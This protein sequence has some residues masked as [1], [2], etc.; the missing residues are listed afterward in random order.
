[1]LDRIFVRGGVLSALGIT[2][3]LLMA[4]TRNNA[5]PHGAV[6]ALAG[7]NAA[8][9]GTATLKVRNDALTRRVVYVAMDGKRQRLGV[10]RAGATTDLAVPQRY[11][12][13]RASVRFLTDPYGGSPLAESQ[14]MHVIAHDTL[15][16]VIL[17]GR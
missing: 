1:M 14:R 2:A 16:M 11:V 12:A 17:P 13:G 8:L 7:H 10:A 3:T 6:A 15:S 9:V 5:L 4:A